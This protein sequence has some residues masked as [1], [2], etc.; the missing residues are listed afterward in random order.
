M[1][2][3]SLAVL[4][5]LV[6]LLQPCAAQESE[7]KPQTARRPATATVSGM[8]VNGITGE[9]VKRA[10]VLLR[11]TPAVSAP[12]SDDDGAEVGGAIVNTGEDGRF[13][14]ESVAPGHYLLAATK[15]GFAGSASGA[16]YFG[17][18]SYRTTRAIDVAAGRYVDDIVLKLMPGGVITG[19]ITDGDGDPIAGVRVSAI[20]QVYGPIRQMVTSATGETNDLGEYRLYGL[21]AGRYLILSNAQ[22]RYAFSGGNQPQ[23]AFPNT[24]YPGATDLTKATAIEV[25]NGD[26]QR[27]D[28]NLVSVPLVHVRGRVIG[29]R[30]GGSVQISIVNRDLPQM[31]EGQYSVSAE[32]GIFHF[33]SVLPG[34]YAMIAVEYSV[35]SGPEP[36]GERIGTVNLDVDGVDI[37]NVQ[38]ALSDR[39]S[40]PIRGRIVST[41]AAAD[42]SGLQV[43]LL[44]IQSEVSSVFG[45]GRSFM[46][47]V[48]KDGTFTINP[49]VDGRYRVLVTT[50]QPKIFTDWFTKAVRL[51]SDD[52][53]SGFTVSGGLSV[54]LEV[55]VS[56]NGGRLTGVVTD[57]DKPVPGATVVVVP[58]AAHGDFFDWYHAA[59]T[60]QYGAFTIRGI[61][62]GNY[63]VFAFDQLEPY[64][65]M[66]P[67]FLKTLLAMGTSAT[68]S[69]GSSQQL[70]L[71]VLKVSGND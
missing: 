24:F 54:P 36:A 19:R 1:N 40:E 70:Q 69:E 60:D 58:D 57:K 3:V 61:D 41:G 6:C 39:R 55:L 62:P 43:T 13:A 31:P 38:I 46:T 68:V 32:D 16:S 50:S 2:K 5:L 20:R 8:V 7:A 48:K 59:E 49:P 28:I 64:S 30:A 37:N 44:S 14:M 26:E 10:I 47:E 51:G 29:A 63:T 52:V 71:K 9:P 34:R 11:R 67:S 53:T 4:I 33:P 45:E 12:E 17:M 65:Y 27:A 21:D 22:P 18:I 66:D 35:R 42:F 15:E 56:P 23:K 25:H